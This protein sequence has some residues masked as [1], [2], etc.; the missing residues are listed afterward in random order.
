[1]FTSWRATK[2]PWRSWT[3]RKLKRWTS[4]GRSEEKSRIW[5]YFA[6]LTLSNC[7][8]WS[9]R[10][11]ISS[12]SW[13]LYQGVNS[14]ITLWR[15]ASWRTRMRG[16]FSNKSSLVCT[17][18]TATWLSIGIWRYLDTFF[19]KHFLERVVS[20]QTS[21]RSLQ[22][23]NCRCTRLARLVFRA[24]LCIFPVFFEAGKPSPGQVLECEDR[25]LWT[26]QHDVWWGVSENQLRLP[27]LC[28]SR[29]DLREAIR[30]AR[31]WHLELRGHSVR[32]AVWHAALWRRTRPDA[33]QKNQIWNLPHP[34]L[35]E[36]GG[37][38]PACAH[39]TSWPLETSYYWSDPRPGMV[40]GGAAGVSLPGRVRPGRVDRGQPSSEGSLREMPSYRRR[41]AQR[42][43]S[44][45]PAGSGLSTLCLPK[46]LRNLLVRFFKKRGDVSGEMRDLHWLHAL[47]WTQ[48]VL[49]KGTSR[50][51]HYTQTIR[52][53]WFCLDFKIRFT[54]FLMN[55]ALQLVIA[56]NL[57]IDNKRIADET[58][59]LQ[60][61][62]F[63]LASSPPAETF[64]VKY[65]GKGS[66]SPVK[67][68]P[69]RMPEMQ[70]VTPRWVQWTL[71]K[72]SK[73]QIVAT[74]EGKFPPHE[75]WPWHV[76]KKMVQLQ[77]GVGGQEKEHDDE[78]SQM[79][80]WNSV[81][82]Q[83]IRHHA[84][85]TRKFVQTLITSCEDRQKLWR[86]WRVFLL[87]F[88]YLPASSESQLYVA[89]VQSHE[90]SGVRVESDES[91]P[92][93]CSAKK[94]RFRSFRQDEPAAVPGNW[95]NQLWEGQRRVFLQCGLPVQRRQKDV[96]FPF[97][98]SRGKPFKTL[99]FFFVCVDKR[100]P[101]A[102]CDFF[103]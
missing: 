1:M 79:A 74:F 54:Q 26:F 18:V 87:N 100:P 75:K 29:G 16:A 35:S 62:D 41:S 65:D 86:E 31:S 47:W 10:R 46:V 103:L 12:W 76:C 61:R 4:W 83:A 102:M 17:T 9:A 50:P 69:E 89:G 27:Q 34:R 96:N 101:G 94:S 3:G 52:S 81:A 72:S 64:M 2:L 77:F 33:V 20:H 71:L 56:Y 97:L 51:T 11:Q 32:L 6:I 45:G 15:M 42:P 7:T 92:R 55:Y 73:T 38:Q 22:A 58:A 23:L 95:G 48:I 59:K 14:L 90:N 40:Q 99:F 37:R 85:G 53:S 44:G 66:Q 93:S 88:K 63:Y 57:V 91:I 21:H 13:S 78:E 70:N 43:V 67:S 36:Q 80:S 98:Q 28:G 84:R 49:R 19:L 8:R 68:H 5:S 60:I 24:Q 39:A 25:R 82:K 30:R